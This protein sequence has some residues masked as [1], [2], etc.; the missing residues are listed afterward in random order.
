MGH[1][2]VNTTNGKG[3]PPRAYED[4]DGSATSLEAFHQQLPS[5][6]GHGHH[7]THDTRVYVSGGGGHENSAKGDDVSSLQ[8]PSRVAADE[9]GSK[10]DG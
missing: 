9:G 2:N 8:Q 1:T 6:G 10:E 4:D 5:R 3:P 7:D